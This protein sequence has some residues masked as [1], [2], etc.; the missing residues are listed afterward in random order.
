MQKCTICL[1]EFQ[2]DDMNII[3]HCNH[4]FHSECVKEWLSKHSYKCPICRIEVGESEAHL[5]Q[6]T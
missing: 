4:H 6:N 2:N 5:S 1:E 3:L